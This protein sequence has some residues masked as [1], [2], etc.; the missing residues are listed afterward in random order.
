MNAYSLRLLLLCLGSFFLV[1]LALGFFARLCAPTVQT[2]VMPLRPRHAADVLLALR[3]GPAA[4]TILLVV[5][6]CV[7]SYLRFEPLAAEES[8]GWFLWIAA[9]LGAAVWLRA[10]VRTLRAL[11]ATRRLRTGPALRLTGILSPKLHVSGDVK[12]VLS[13]DQWKTVLRHEEAHIISFDNLKRLLILLAPGLTPVDNGWERLEEAWVAASEQAADA[14]AVDGDSGKAILL[15]EALVRLARHGLDASAEQLA[16]SF[17]TN[18]EQLRMRV[19]CL[20]DQPP[21]GT[22][23]SWILPA[24]AAALFVLVAVAQVYQQQ[25]HEWLELLVD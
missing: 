4:I 18:P 5:A 3:L 11:R 17:A 20:L 24:S 7:P 21:A 14:V 15:A 8:V 22:H 10:C 16:S 1:H 9:A 23:R 25:V 13:E 19:Q 6:L 2:W 12:A